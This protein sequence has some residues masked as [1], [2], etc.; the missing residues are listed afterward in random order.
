M[1]G[2]GN[3]RNRL[4]IVDREMPG[5]NDPRRQ[6]PS[7]TFDRFVQSI[8]SKL[9]EQH[10]DRSADE[11]SAISEAVAEGSLGGVTEVWRELGHLACH[12]DMRDGESALVSSTE[13]SIEEIGNGDEGEFIREG[14]CE[15]CE[16]DVKL[17]RHHLIPKTCWPKMKKRLH[18]ASPVLQ[19]L[20]AMKGGKETG[21]AMLQRQLL[22]KI[23]GQDFSPEELPSTIT[24]ESVRAYLSQVCLSCRQCH[25]AVH[26][27]H[28]EWELAMHYHTMDRLLTSPEVL[29]FAKWAS[30]Q[31]KQGKS[32]IK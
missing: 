18:L 31:K 2:K 28:P 26:R 10:R 12:A 30:K 14:E 17:T 6:P 15:L 19:S 29:K 24:N 1:G 9:E 25:S 23:M 21:G 13:E 11:I 20:H 7:S 22:Q 4:R 5:E 32:R 3:R 16:R 27:V 8:S